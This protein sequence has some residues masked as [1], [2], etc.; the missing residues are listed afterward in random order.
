MEIRLRNKSLN[1][2]PVPTPNAQTP[3]EP[4][5]ID[6]FTK[7]VVYPSVLYPHLLPTSSPSHG[8]AM[9]TFRTQRTPEGTGTGTD[10][11]SPN[12][13]SLDTLRFPELVGEATDNVSTSFDYGLGNT[14]VENPLVDA[15]NGY[16]AHRDHDHITVSVLRNKGKTSV[17][18]FSHYPEEEGATVGLSTHHQKYSS[19]YT[20]KALGR[21]FQGLLSYFSTS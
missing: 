4:L 14:I 3:L 5:D 12:S 13:E 20:N 9:D 18:N 6:M 21:F 1:T 16:E 19:R 10:S 7:A 17:L 8:I 15:A 11:N 2:F